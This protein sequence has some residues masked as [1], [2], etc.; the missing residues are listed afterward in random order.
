MGPKAKYKVQKFP[1]F[2]RSP[3][4]SRVLEN[5]GVMISSGRS[6]K[7]LSPKGTQPDRQGLNWSETGAESKASRGE[8]S[9]IN[10]KANEYKWRYLYTVF[11]KNY[12]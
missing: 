4:K 5:S 3:K 1:E 8:V 6:R 11:I 7:G 12:K 2:W 9:D 10:P